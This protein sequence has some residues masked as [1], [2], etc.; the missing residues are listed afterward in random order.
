MNISSE[1]D[2]AELTLLLDCPIDLAEYDTP[3]ISSNR[4]NTYKYPSSTWQGNGK[5]V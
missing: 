5:K 3:A 2:I 4:E 1:L